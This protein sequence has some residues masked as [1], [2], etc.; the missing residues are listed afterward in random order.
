MVALR[1]A[2]WPEIASSGFQLDWVDLTD[3]VEL[4]GRH[5]RP[6]RYGLRL[7][8]RGRGRSSDRHRDPESTAGHD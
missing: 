2:A 1:A 3:G 4:G 7:C 5:S 8:I 6:C